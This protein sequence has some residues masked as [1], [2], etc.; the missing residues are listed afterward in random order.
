MF[1]KEQLL[2]LVR[3]THRNKKD[4]THQNGSSKKTSYHSV[5]IFMFVVDIRKATTV[6]KTSDWYGTIAYI[7]DDTYYKYIDDVVVRPIPY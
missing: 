6:D 2:Q 5:M 1:Q 3:N 7:K 4:K